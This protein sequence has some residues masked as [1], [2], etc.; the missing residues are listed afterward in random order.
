LVSIAKKLNATVYVNAI[1]GTKLYNKE[2]FKGQGIELQFVQ[3]QKL[4]LKEP[5]LSVLHQLM[6]YSPEHLQEQLIKYQLI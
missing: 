6:N 1:G 3:T 2:F 4:D 5:E